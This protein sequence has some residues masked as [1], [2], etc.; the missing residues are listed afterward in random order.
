MTKLT[1]VLL[2]VYDILLWTSFVT[3]GLMNV[4]FQLDLTNTYWLFVSFAAFLFLIC[5]PLCFVGS[6]YIVYDL[7]NATTNVR[8]DRYNFIKR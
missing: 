6:L 7:F 4:L 5:L 2:C 8:L 1:P 3:F